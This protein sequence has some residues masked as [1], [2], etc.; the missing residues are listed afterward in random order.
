MDTAGNR[1]LREILQYRAS[2]TPDYLFVRF[3]P[4]ESETRDFTWSAFDKQVNRTANALAALGIGAG[5]K[6]NLH[7]SN[8]ME[9]L[10]LW[11]AAAKLRAVIMPTKCSGM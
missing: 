4:I 2:R 10:F 5:D 1:T 8:C 11:F 3:D 9:F 6:I 7:L